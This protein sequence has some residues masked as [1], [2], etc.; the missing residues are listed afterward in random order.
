MKIVKKLIGAAVAAGVACLLVQVVKTEKVQSWLYSGKN[1]DITFAV[2]EKIRL[3][4]D[5]LGWPIHFV[6]ALLP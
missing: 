2:E 3:L 6:K 1:E 5:L 4:G